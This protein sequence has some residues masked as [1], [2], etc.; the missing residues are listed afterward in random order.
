PAE[1]AW[2]SGRVKGLRARNGFE[3]D[4]QWQEGRL[5]NAEITST[6]GAKAVV[7]L[8]AGMAVFNKKGRKIKVEMVRGTIVQFKTKKGERYWVR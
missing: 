3:V 7:Q 1:A 8:P 6:S 2:R 5:M 4:I